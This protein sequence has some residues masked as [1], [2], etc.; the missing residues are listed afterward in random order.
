MSY[1]ETSEK[2][3]HDFRGRICHWVYCRNCGLVALRN[4]T[5]QRRI[6]Q[7]CTG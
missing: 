1:K 3:K 6:A 7:R 4:E 5:T 2:G